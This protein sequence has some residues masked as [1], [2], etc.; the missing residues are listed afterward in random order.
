MSSASDDAVA[1]GRRKQKR[2]WL[3]QSGA[4]DVIVQA[5]SGQWLARAVADSKQRFVGSFATQAEAEAALAAAKQTPP[6]L[7][8]CDAPPPPPQELPPID[9]LTSAGAEEEGAHDDEA[10][11]AAVLEAV[12]NLVAQVAWQASR[13]PPPTHY[14]RAHDLSQAARM[15]RFGAACR[16][17]DASHWA[18]SDHPLDH[19]LLGQLVPPLAALGGSGGEFALATLHACAHWHQKGFCLAGSACRFVHAVSE[20]GSQ[21]AAPSKAHSAKDKHRV[22]TT[23]GWR[24]R[25]RR[26]GSRG[27][28]FRRFLIDAFGLDALRAGSGVRP[29]LPIFVFGVCLNSII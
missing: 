7:S 14:G 20:R 25:G 26:N 2:H 1:L 21:L 10:V 22:R 15:C 6:P 4:E 3:A 19:P 27:A 29:R 28:V 23:G 16:R 18:E 13:P 11:G 5:Q 17:A 24:H 12:R 8:S 9:E